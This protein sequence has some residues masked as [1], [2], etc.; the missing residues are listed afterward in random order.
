MLD[1]RKAVTVVFY[2]LLDLLVYGVVC[3]PIDPHGRHSRGPMLVAVCAEASRSKCVVH[4]PD[5]VEEN[6]F[7]SP[8]VI[9]GEEL[10]QLPWI[11]GP[12]DNVVGEAPMPATA[13]EG[14]LLLNALSRKVP[15]RVISK[16][17]PF[18]P[19]KLPSC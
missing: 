7:L 4:T 15:N 18:G 5:V 12:S 6:S 9:A 19:T 1:Y 3:L 17:I 11:V 16:E 14:R 13:V 2:L 10:G 8:V